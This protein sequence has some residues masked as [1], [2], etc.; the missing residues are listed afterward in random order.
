MLNLF[1]IITNYILLRI[2]LLIEINFIDVELNMIVN[3]LNLIILIKII[4][5]KTFVILIWR[6]TKKNKIFFLYNIN[7]NWFFYIFFANFS[8]N[9]F[10]VMYDLFNAI[11]NWIDICCEFDENINNKYLILNMRDNFD[12]SWFDIFN[13]I[14]KIWFNIIDDVDAF[15]DDDEINLKSNLNLI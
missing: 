3:I 12:I 14:I 6:K 15:C 13:D 9:L 4:N 2:M 11:Y 10:I 8:K 1:C 7:L 5:L